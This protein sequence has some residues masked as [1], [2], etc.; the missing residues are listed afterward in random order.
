M[1]NYNEFSK[2]L[3]KKYSIR[4]SNYQLIDITILSRL[5]GLAFHPEPLNQLR[6]L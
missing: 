2:N 6:A 4:F 5:I 3:K 1:N